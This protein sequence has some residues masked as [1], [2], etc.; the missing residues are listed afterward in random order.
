MLFAKFLLI[1]VIVIAITAGIALRVKRF[2]DGRSNRGC[3]SEEQV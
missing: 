2:R 1:A 3:G